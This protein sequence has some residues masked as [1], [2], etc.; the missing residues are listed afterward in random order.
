MPD[1]FRFPRFWWGEHGA[2]FLE[3]EL[4]L[5]DLLQE[6][7]LDAQSAALLWA[8]LARRASL[9]V[10]G[11]YQR[12]AGKTTTLTALT[13][14]LPPHTTLVFAQGR[15]EDFSFLDQVAADSTYIL[16]NEFSDHTPWY[17]WGQKAARVFDLAQEGFAFVGTMHAESIDDVIGQLVEPPVALAG[18]SLST[19]LQLVAMQGIF[20]EGGELK[21]RLTSLSWLY[22]TSLGPNGIGVKSLVAW[23][24]RDDQWTLFSS[25]TTWEQLAQWTKVP[26]AALEQEV[27]RRGHYLQDVAARSLT[28]YDGV[29]TALLQFA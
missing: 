13:G 21:R 3:P 18:A 10:V 11:G 23:S 26:A 28:D 14:C 24:P 6:H 25:P 22:P 12:G 1:S 7:V 2:D 5:I 19:S 17:L 4:S 15:A 8:L 20:G 16:V 27:E 9:I 29:R